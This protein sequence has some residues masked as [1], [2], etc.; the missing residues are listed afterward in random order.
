MLVKNNLQS[1][2]KFLSYHFSYIQIKP[3]PFNALGQYFAEFI[4]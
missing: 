1:F 3:Q 2:I 4:K